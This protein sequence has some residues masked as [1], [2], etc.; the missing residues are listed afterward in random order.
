MTGP[1]SRKTAVSPP[2][3]YKAFVKFECGCIGI[4]VGDQNYLKLYDCHTSDVDF[5]IWSV[6]NTPIVEFESFP[7]EKSKLFEMFRKKLIAANAF[8]KLK[9][10]LGLKDDNAKVEDDSSAR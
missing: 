2:N 9:A 3:I 1:R 5:V 8:I 10:I 4:S 7:D 6:P